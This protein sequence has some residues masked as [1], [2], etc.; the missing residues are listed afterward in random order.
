MLAACCLERAFGLLGALCG[1]VAP[2]LGFGD[3]FLGLVQRLL[4]GLQ[5]EACPFQLSD[6]FLGLA[7]G[8]R[9]FELLASCRLFR[10]LQR[11]RG[12]GP[13][14]LR[15]CSLFGPISGFDCDG[16]RDGPRAVSMLTGAGFGLSTPD[17]PTIDRP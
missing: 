2:A 16:F 15:P 10:V 8:A 12:L 17:D 1:R 5:R 3:G 7:C 13:P 6:R 4:G 11:F 14:R 9:G